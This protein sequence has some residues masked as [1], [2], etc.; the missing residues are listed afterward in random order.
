MSE[1]NSNSSV[2]SIRDAKKEDARSIAQFQVAMALETEGKTLDLELVLNAA[3]AVF[4]DASKGFYLVAEVGT[5]VV[6]SLL[7]TFEWSDWRNHMIWYFQSVFVTQEHR[8]QGIFGAMYAKVMQLAQSA[9]VKVVRLYVET[10]NEQAQRVYE[11]LGMKRLPY[12]MYETK[13]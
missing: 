13:V 2:F 9:D 11:Q 7:I 1:T 5:E 12:Y 3:N 6:A 4:D 10:D 8:G